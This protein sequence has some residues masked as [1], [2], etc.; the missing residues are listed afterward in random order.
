MRFS[1]IDPYLLIEHTHV[2]ELL[3]LLNARDDVRAMAAEPDPPRTGL[4][5]DIVPKSSTVPAGPR[6]AA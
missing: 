6:R 1:D 5:T 4:D 3:A 2:D